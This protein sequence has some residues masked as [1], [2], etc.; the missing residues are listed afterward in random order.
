MGLGIWVVTGHRYLGGYI[1]DGEA[2]RSWLKEKI[3]VWTD[4]VNIPAK[5]AQKH[6]QSAYA[7]L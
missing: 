6:P 2:E 3:Q 1:R 7:G 4:S 5:V